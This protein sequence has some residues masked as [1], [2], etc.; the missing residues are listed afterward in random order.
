MRFQHP[1]IDWSQ[2]SAVQPG[3]RRSGSSSGMG[4]VTCMGLGLRVV[5]IGN[6]M[7]ATGILS[8]SNPSVDLRTERESAM[9]NGPENAASTAPGPNHSERKVRPMAEEPLPTIAELRQLLRYEPETGKLFWRKRNRRTPYEASI[10][11]QTEGVKRCI[12]LGSFMTMEEAAA[13]R[14][15]AEAELGYH[16][17]HGRR[18]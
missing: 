10:A 2:A 15:K 9:K 12:Y 7:A 5:P 13:A 4:G 3:A 11:V 14:K 1:V 8:P 16:A 17:N 18:A 6:T